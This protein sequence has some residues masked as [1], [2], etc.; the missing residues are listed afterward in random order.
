MPEPPQPHDKSAS[1][2]S[3]ERLV[4]EDG[5]GA[6]ASGLAQAQGSNVKNLPKAK[7]AQPPGFKGG[8]QDVP[9]GSGGPRGCR[10]HCFEDDYMDDDDDD[11]VYDKESLAEAP[12]DR[13]FAHLV[14]YIYEGF[15]HSEPQSAASSA[16]RCEYESYF[17]NTKKPVY[18]YS[19]ILCKANLLEYLST[20]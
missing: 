15:P 1:V 2:K 11:D 12:L 3:R 8:F 20:F 9:S 5:T 7:V 10:E 13:A 17:K 6:Q 19:T 4:C 16:P 14:D 18:S